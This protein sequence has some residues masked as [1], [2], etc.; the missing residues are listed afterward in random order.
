MTG[1]AAFWSQAL[2][3]AVGIVAAVVCFVVAWWWV[4][5]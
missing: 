5:R 3:I 2:P 4:T 1:F